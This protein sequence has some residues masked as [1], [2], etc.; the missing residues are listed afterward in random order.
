[1]KRIF[2]YIIF[3]FTASYTISAQAAWYEV[4]GSSTILSNESEAR[5]LALEDATYQAMVFSG[6]DM[7]S[8]K[9][10]RPFLE[11][12]E[13]D[14]QFS[15]SEVRQIQIVNERTKDGKYYLTARMDIYPSANSCHTTQYKK[16]FLVG[17]IDLV[18][19]QQ[20]VMGKIYQ[21]GDDLSALFTRQINTE[22]QSFISVGVTDLEI[23][24]D[25]PSTMKMIAEDTGAHYIIGGSITDLSATIDQKLLQSDQTNRQFALSMFVIDGK[26][27][28]TIY[29]NNYREIAEWPFAKTSHVD[30]KSARF[31]T[32]SYGQM[33]LRVSRNI[34]LDLEGEFACKMTLP[35]V[36]AVRGNKVSID[37]G[38]IHGVQQGDTLDLWHTSS[39]ID[40]RGLPRNK[41]SKTA[42][43]LTVTRIYEQGAELEINQPQL[44]SSVQIGDVMHIQIE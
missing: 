35:Q 15:N 9:H 37:L 6:G 29:Q 25:R 1:M 30:T 27:G 42:I 36:V 24:Q 19:P 41:V 34:M 32:S 43:T 21:I 31:W 44:A 26:T 5:L 39:F 16:T 33:I 28:Q 4:T 10:L 38:R 13:D 18:S 14:Y 8:L 7:S 23:R 3:I 22:S 40:Q 20:A 12:G 2:L 11:K 17:N